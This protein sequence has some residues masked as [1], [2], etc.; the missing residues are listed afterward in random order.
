MEEPREALDGEA[1]DLTQ[2][3]YNGFFFSQ[4]K[5]MGIDSFNS[6]CFRETTCRLIWNLYRIY[7]VYSVFL[8]GRGLVNS[9]VG[10]IFVV[11]DLDS[12]FYPNK[13]LMAGH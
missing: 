13:S 10:W 2:R 12:V 3:V 4:K 11:L 5:R 7:H 6:D 9:H 1:T 8:N